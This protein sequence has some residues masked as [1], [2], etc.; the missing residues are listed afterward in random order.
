MKKVPAHHVHS[1]GGAPPI[2]AYTGRLS[3]KVGPFFRIQGFHYLRY[4]KLRKGR[5]ICLFGLQQG[6][7]GLTVAFYDYE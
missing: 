4:I 1:G 3:P 7:E 5:E 6:P 2:R